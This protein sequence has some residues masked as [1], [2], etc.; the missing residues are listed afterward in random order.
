MDILNHLDNV[1][2]DIDLLLKDNNYQFN[3]KKIAIIKEN[4]LNF[5]ENLGENGGVLFI[6]LSKVKEVSNLIY[7]LNNDNSFST[8][9]DHI[10]TEFYA[11]EFLLQEEL[12]RKEV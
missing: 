5:K 9:T 6:D 1:L 4:L 2:Q 7:E 10:S 12:K 3:D 11:F 8:L